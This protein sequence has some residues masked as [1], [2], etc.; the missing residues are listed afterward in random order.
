M[1]KKGEIIAIRHGETYNNMNHKF[2]GS[3]SDPELT[4]NGIKQAEHLADMLKWQH[5]DKLY[6]SPSDRATT[7]TQIVCRG[8]LNPKDIK[9]NFDKRLRDIDVGYFTNKPENKLTR[10][11]LFGCTKLGEM[12]VE[13]LDNLI[14]RVTAFW[15][16]INESDE[17]ALIT[18]LRIV[19]STLQY[20]QMGKPKSF[21]KFDLLTSP[22]A[23]GEILTLRD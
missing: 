5:F 14:N 18:T 10:C 6:S 8:L 3:G 2:S 22:V 9:W 15:D 23:Q 12:K 21:K 11:L 4:P 19:L 20:C 17:S 1:I 13:D 16:E 7:T